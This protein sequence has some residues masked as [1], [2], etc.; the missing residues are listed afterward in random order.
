MM[1]IDIDIIPTKKTDFLWGDLKRQLYQDAGT[2]GVSVVAIES[3]S[4]R[5]LGSN[6]VL[7]EADHI[8]VPGY[9]YFSNSDPCTL[10]LVVEPFAGEA[11]NRDYMDNFGRFLSEA[12]RRT[13]L[14]QWKEASCEY[15]VSSAGGRPD[16]ELRTLVL[17]SSSLAVLTNGYCV[18]RDNNIFPLSLGI[19]TPD[20]MQQAGN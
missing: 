9:Y 2:F 13:I 17:V 1:S 7:L 3:L 16:G 15:G 18:I 10:S 11:E 12:D 14:R 19:Y 5:E 4:L 6:R 8:S 20:Q